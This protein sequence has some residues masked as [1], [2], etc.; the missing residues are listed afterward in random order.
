[1]TRTPTRGLIAVAS[2][3][4]SMVSLGCSDE[5]TPVNRDGGRDSG[6]ADV[7]RDGHGGGPDGAGP[8][9]GG[10]RICR[11]DSECDDLDPCSLDRCDLATSRCQSTRDTS[12]S[13]V[14]SGGTGRP[15][16]DEGRQGVENDMAAGGLVV[17]AMARNTD[18]LWI[19]NT[20]ESTLSKWDATTATELA[21]YR[22]GL[23]EG[24]C[25]G[26]CCHE[27]G[28]NMPSRTVVDGAGD[29]Y[30]AN[31]GFGMQGSVSKIA[32]DRRDCIDRNGNGMIDTSTGPMD[33][34]PFGEDECV[35]W[36]S[37][38]GAPGILLRS[39]TIDKGDESNPQ[40]TP[41][42]GACGDLNSNANGG[43]FQLNPRTGEVTRPIAFGRC[44]YG[45]TVTPDGTLWEHSAYNAITPINTVS[46]EVGASIPVP[47]GMRAGCTSS[48]GITA[49]IRGR[50]WLSGRNCRDVLGYDPAMRAWTRVDLSP[51]IPV[52][53]ASG[54]GIT[55]DPSN[56]VWVPISTATDWQGPTKVAFFDAD[57]FMAGATVPSSRAT[58]LTPSMPHANPTA[59][60]ADRAGN[61]WVASAAVGGQ[62]LRY[63]PTLSRWD[64][65]GGPNRV[66]TYT[67]F[68]GG[69]RR[70]LIG[71]GRYSEDYE[72]CEG[73]TYGE[74]V[75]SA[76][77]PAG[78]SLTFAIQLADS[79]TGLAMATSITLGIAPRDS[80]PI[81]IAEK[82]RAAGVMNIG[83]F[84]RLTVTFTPNSSPVASPVLR[85][86][87]FTWR[88][89][90]AG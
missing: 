34:R 85:S 25:V 33:V 52:G 68:T 77:T 20:N 43:L 21:R 48:Y 9:G 24:E 74:L 73:G 88:C 45:A 8:D 51:F 83:R 60:G 29:A 40:G 23:P 50:I 66:Y 67:D 62:L 87:A 19:P 54:L 35:L 84:A 13:S 17:R 16:S 44:A 22:V 32:A 2:I 39:L 10:E 58:E 70:L 65:F 63:Q 18:F 49:D 1:M 72:T 15:F 76:D 82:L 80:S 81:N 28:C 57:V 56:R 42:V 36:T 4:V 27:N 11:S 38:V 41:W 6:T 30:V 55:V 89:G 47:T 14:R 86:M 46:G 31:R 90:G 78:T 75:W 71:T 37:R 26:R 7:V 79:R 5:S 59:I 53:G 12:C 69:V 64:A 61:I 3:A